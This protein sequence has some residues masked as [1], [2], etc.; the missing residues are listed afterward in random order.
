M[1]GDDG[2]SVSTCSARSNT[3]CGVSG[4]GEWLQSLNHIRGVLFAIRKTL[5]RHILI[6]T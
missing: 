3:G 1:T 5:S 2:I 4:R 6:L